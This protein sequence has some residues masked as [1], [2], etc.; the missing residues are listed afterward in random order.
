MI[1]LTTQIEFETAHSVGNISE[2][3]WGNEV[4]NLG[5]PEDDGRKRVFFS[6]QGRSAK[7]QAEDF[8]GLY[9]GCGLV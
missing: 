8:T 1:F 7:L 5:F 9:L 4:L 2:V 3:A 6:G